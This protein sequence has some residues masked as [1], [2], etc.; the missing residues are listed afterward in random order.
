MVDEGGFLLD[1][2]IQQVQHLLVALESQ[3]VLAQQGAGAG[4]QA[5]QRVRVEPA[6]LGQVLGRDLPVHEAVGQAHEGRLPG[7]GA[8]G[9]P[10]QEGIQGPGD[11]GLPLLLHQVFQDQAQRQEAEPGMAIGGGELQGRLQLVLR[12]LQK[13][14]AQLEPLGALAPAFAADALE[15]HFGAFGLVPPR[16]A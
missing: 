11:L 3:Q 12:V 5:G 14:Q 16:P 1:E 10:C 8:L 13:G 7:P 6:D 9:M 15:Q 2:G 4:F